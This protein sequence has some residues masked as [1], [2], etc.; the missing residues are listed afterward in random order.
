M[1]NVLDIVINFIGYHYHAKF[2]RAA[3]KSQIY[4]LIRHLNI[5]M[6]VR[7][8]WCSGYSLEIKDRWFE[9]SSGIGVQF[10]CT[11]VA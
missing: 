4:G 9:P 5:K 10:M 7:G 6:S 1:K 8:L 2:K 3:M 11:K